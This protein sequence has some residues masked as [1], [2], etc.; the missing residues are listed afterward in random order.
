MELFKIIENVAT[1]LLKLAVTKLPDSIEKAL[2]KAL[3]EVQSDVAKTQLQTIVE[4]FTAAKTSLLPMCQ[5]TG[6]VSFFVKVGEQFPIIAELTEIL[7]NATI[8]AT[9]SVPLRPNAVDLFKGNTGNNVADYI[10]WIYWEIVPNNNVLELI[11]FPKGG[12]STNISKLGL[13]KPG[14]GLKGIKKFIVDS[15]VDAGAKGCPP[16]FL[17]IG[18]GGGEDIAM[19]LAKKSLLR[20]VGEHSKIQKIAELE[21][22]L[23]EALNELRIGVMGLGEGP[24]VL[25]VHIEVA[26]RHP[27]SLPIG[28][29][30]S[31]WADRHAGARIDSEGNITYLSF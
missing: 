25:S 15:V 12:G 16:Y 26:G 10:P 1:E 20:P 14:E 27:A 18:I 7:R 8:K 22:E 21:K 2:L 13:L 3:E 29:V 17:G 4:N 28:I 23:L 19:N 6:V 9:Q 5:D 31:C 11:A 30:F 24:T